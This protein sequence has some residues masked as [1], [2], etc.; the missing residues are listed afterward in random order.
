[1]TMRI[2]RQQEDP[3]QS[4]VRIIWIT[5][6]DPPPPPLTTSASPPSTCCEQLPAGGMGATGMGEMLLVADFSPNQITAC[7]WMSRYHD[8]GEDL[9]HMRERVHAYEG[10]GQTLQWQGGMRE[11]APP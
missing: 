5:Q 3:T 8:M 9:H 10:Q 7:E 2:R 4:M 6:Q 1:M 11:G